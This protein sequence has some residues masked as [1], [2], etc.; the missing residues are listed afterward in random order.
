M[1]RHLDEPRFQMH[2]TRPTIRRA[3]CVVCWHNPPLFE[4]TAHSIIPCVRNVIFLLAKS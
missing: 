3:D 1:R 4:I 2:I